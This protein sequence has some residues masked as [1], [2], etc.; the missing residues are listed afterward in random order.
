M[1]LLLAAGLVVLLAGCTSCGPR[2]TEVA[3]TTTLAT[4]FGPQEQA[5]VDAALH[6]AGFLRQNPG[7]YGLVRATRGPQTVDV[8]DGEGNTTDVRIAFAIGPRS[9]ADSPA[10]EQDADD[11]VR[12]ESAALQPDANAT[13][14][15]VLQALAQPSQPTPPVGGAFGIC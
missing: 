8:S 10:G 9:F 14:A 11:Y 5:S 7:A 15:L 6:Q 2:V 4:A 13:F 3:A 1:R 12:N